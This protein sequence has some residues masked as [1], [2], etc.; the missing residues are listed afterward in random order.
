[1]KRM[2]II[3]LFRLPFIRISQSHIPE[4]ENVKISDLVDISGIWRE[5]F[6][7]EDQRINN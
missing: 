6:Q 2:G 1:M 3:Y 5:T 4:N 7:S